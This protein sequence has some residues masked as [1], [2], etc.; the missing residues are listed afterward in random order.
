M[1][2]DENRGSLPLSNLRYFSKDP[3]DVNDNEMLP[4]GLKHLEESGS[5][6]TKDYK[7]LP[8]NDSDY[9][10]GMMSDLR[11]YNQYL[12]PEDIDEVMIDCM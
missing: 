1:I 7:I 10:D 9:F 8:R 2:R 3:D 4:H 12:T 5:K 6:L 11:F